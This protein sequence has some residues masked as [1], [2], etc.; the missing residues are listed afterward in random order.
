[1][2]EL[3]LA[4]GRRVWEVHSRQ[5]ENH[6]VRYYEEML[7]GRASEGHEEGI[8]QWVVNEQNI[9]GLMRKWI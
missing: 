8:H 1:M 2:K 9:Q 4:I 7:R 6:S 3:E 5:M